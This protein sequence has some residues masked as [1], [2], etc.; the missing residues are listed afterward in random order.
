MSI[1]ERFVQMAE[2]SL[3]PLSVSRVRKILDGLSLED[4]PRLVIQESERVIV[5]PV[6]FADERIS[7]VGL[8]TREEIV[9]GH[10]FLVSSTSSQNL[11]MVKCRRRAPSEQTRRVRHE[12]P[13]MGGALR[14]ELPAALGEDF[15]GALISDLK[16]RPPKEEIVHNRAAA[17]KPSDAW[18]RAA[19]PKAASSRRTPRLGVRGDGFAVGDVG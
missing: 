13:A 18:E 6:M 2:E 4:C 5:D 1:G 11:F 10:L 17:T 16:V 3:F 15:D 14:V 8:K 12:L 7:T 19:L 9:A